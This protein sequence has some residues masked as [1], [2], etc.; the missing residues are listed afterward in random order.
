MSEK[1]TD[2][3]PLNLD[4][5]RQRVAEVVGDEYYFVAH[6]SNDGPWT[7]LSLEVNDKSV[8]ENPL[9]T[10][11]RMITVDISN[12]VAAAGEPFTFSSA[13]LYG[14]SQPLTVT[15]IV[16]VDYVSEFFTNV[17]AA[18]GSMWAAPDGTFPTP[19]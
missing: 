11:G 17:N 15:Y 16:K 13:I 12:A 18:E 1:K 7:L 19:E 4:E 5:I 3:K 10:F 2:E 9:S 6:T 8:I 14:P